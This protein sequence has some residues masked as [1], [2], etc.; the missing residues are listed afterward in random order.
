MLVGIVWIVLS[1]T[2]PAGRRRMRSTI[3]TTGIGV[4]IVAALDWLGLFP[5]MPPD[6]PATALIVAMMVLL[7]IAFVLAVIVIYRRR[8]A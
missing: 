2:L 1:T 7:Q 3:V 8:R 5:T 6:R 4:A